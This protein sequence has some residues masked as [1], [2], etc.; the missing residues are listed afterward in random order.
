MHAFFVGV[1]I[2]LFVE[3]VDE[4]VRTW[5]VNHRARVQR[6]REERERQ[7]QAY[8]RTCPPPPRRPMPW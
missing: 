3:I 8:L 5:R 6:Q 2:F 7:W 4:Y 1:M